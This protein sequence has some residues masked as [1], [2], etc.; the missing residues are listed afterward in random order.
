MVRAVYGKHKSDSRKLRETLKISVLLGQA[1][2]MPPELYA[3]PVERA[4]GLETTVDELKLKSQF[5][6]FWIKEFPIYLAY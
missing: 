4:F 3:A 6:N 5:R 2:K 1:I